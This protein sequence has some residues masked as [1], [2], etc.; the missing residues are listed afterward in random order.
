[1]VGF[2]FR[3]IG[4]YVLKVKNAYIVSRVSPICRHLSYTNKNTNVEKMS[5]KCT[6]VVAQN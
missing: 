3:R 6:I 1:M 2:V 4:Q 5:V